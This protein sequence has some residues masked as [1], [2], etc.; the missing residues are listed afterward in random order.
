MT[1]VFGNLLCAD[2]VLEKRPELA[3]TLGRQLEYPL[4]KSLINAPEIRLQNLPDLIFA[5]DFWYLNRELKTAEK[6][7]EVIGIASA[8]DL[9]EL[10]VRKDQ[11]YAASAHIV[12][13][14]E[15]LNRAAGFAG[16]AEQVSRLVYN[17]D[18]ARRQGAPDIS[19]NLNH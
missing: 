8:F 1:A 17:D 2:Q 18:V 16:L 13:I 10:N 6:L 4:N 15:K 7:L 19:L 5:R 14:A 11:R 3:V 12:Q 9:C